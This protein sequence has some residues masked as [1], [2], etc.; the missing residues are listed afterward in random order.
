M[1]IG[2]N[3]EKGLEKSNRKKSRKKQRKEKVLAIAKGL[4]CNRDPVPKHL[5]IVKTL[6]ANSNLSK[7]ISTVWEMKHFR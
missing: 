7:N 4:F 2:E 3:K 6:T 1:A 5:K